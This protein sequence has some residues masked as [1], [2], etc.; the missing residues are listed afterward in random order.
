[1]ATSKAAGASKTA[2]IADELI[3]PKQAEN[4]FAKL[5]LKT[6][7]LIYG[8]EHFLI[9]DLAREIT[10]RLKKAAG[11]HF[12]HANAKHIN[13]G[14]PSF[15]FGEFLSS[16]DTFSLF[17][18][19]DFNIKIIRGLEEYGASSPMLKK[20]CKYLDAIDKKGAE[21]N[22]TSLVILVYAVK[23]PLADVVKNTRNFTA[24]NCKKMYENDILA[25]TRKLAARSGKSFTD[26][27]MSALTERS[28]MNMFQINSEIK[29]LAILNHDRAEI[30]IETVENQVEIFFDPDSFGAI[31]ELDDSVYKKDIQKTVATIGDLL[32]HGVYH[33]LV[34]NRLLAIFRSML[35][36]LLLNEASETFKNGAYK[37]ADEFVR[38]GAYKKGYERFRFSSD[39]LSKFEF[40]CAGICNNSNIYRSE[41][42]HDFL[43]SLKNQMSLNA[44]Y[45]LKNYTEKELFGLIKSLYQIDVKIRT[46]VLRIDQRPESVKEEIYKILISHFKKL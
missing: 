20:F 14:D 25:Y 36:V 24:I 19:E 5:N 2:V 35:S 26:D 39:M 10:S 27:A 31:N 28:R 44:V 8:E 1:M 29:R 46:G 13:I 40:F 38:G 33:A 7:I 6:N 41:S 9:D 37:I 21:E 16:E 22:P 34:V 15:D 4:I 43:N 12:A 30:D 3:F 45:Y 32:D 18:A 42:K 11:A 17:G 23:K